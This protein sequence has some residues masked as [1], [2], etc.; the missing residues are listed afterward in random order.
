MVPCLLIGFTNMAKENVNHPSHYN[1]G[2]I[3]A[4]DAM[5]AAFGKAEV[6]AFCKINSFKYIWRANEKGK[7]TEDLKKARWY[8]DKA[9]ELLEESPQHLNID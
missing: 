5:I 1:Q 9:V 6:V 3:E 4:I 8:L 7:T 2:G